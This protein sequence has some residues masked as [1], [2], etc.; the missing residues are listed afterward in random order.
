LQ[1][2]LAALVSDAIHIQDRRD[3]VGRRGYDPPLYQSQ[4]SSADGDNVW[5]QEQTAVM[6]D[7]ALRA[8]R[9]VALQREDS[10]YGRAQEAGTPRGG[11]IFSE[12]P[13]PAEG[14][15]IWRREQQMGSLDQGVAE[16]PWVASPPV[17]FPQEQHGG[18]SELARM[19]V[20]EAEYLAENEAM[21]LQLGVLEDAVQRGTVHVTQAE[22]ALMSA[23]NRA[24]GVQNQAVDKSHAD[25]FR[26]VSLDGNRASGHGREI[27][28]FVIS[29]VA[30]VGL[31]CFGAGANPADKSCK[32][33]VEEHIQQDNDEAQLWTEIQHQKD[34]GGKF[35]FFDHI[36]IDEDGG[37]DEVHQMFDRLTIM[38]LVGPA[39][40][41]LFLFYNSEY[42]IAADLKDINTPNPKMNDMWTLTGVLFGPLLSMANGSKVGVAGV[43]VVA[44]LEISALLVLWGLFLYNLFIGFT[45]RG[46]LRWKACCDICWWL[47]PYMGSF[48]AMGLL[49]FIS[50]YVLVDDLSQ[51]MTGMKD[52]ADDAGAEQPSGMQQKIKLAKA[53]AKFWSF[54]LV[55]LV[56]GF[57]AFLAKYR[58][59]SEFINSSEVSVDNMMA[60]LVFVNQLLGI[61]QVA[62]LI[63][64]R[65]F[66]FV[67]GGADGILEIKE[68]ARQVV[69]NAML[70]QYIF[71]FSQGLGG[72]AA[73]RFFVVMM[74]YTDM[75]FQ[76]MVLN[77]KTKDKEMQEPGAPAPQAPTTNLSQEDRPQSSP[78]TKRSQED[79]LRS[80]Q[81]PAAPRDDDLQQPLQGRREME[82]F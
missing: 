78:E 69:Y 44:G 75:D 68:Q 74:N 65:L 6:L 58:V 40:G 61:M 19:Q 8:E 39:L 77:E 71:Q 70:A 79:K 43:R 26:V 12:R 9:R 35:V 42:V 52:M 14:D 82:T 45:T 1:G 72:P 62:L 49:Y 18:T 63:R 3:T 54:R 50:P 30:I 33:E 46:R 51:L 15:K 29:V 73:S 22:N 80:S 37:F 57:D 7:A 31:F 11:T 64:R 20:E 28:I 81:R 23:G 27:G 41:V 4:L 60:S 56:I 47:I 48:S 67:F 55:C 2:N 59:A 53:M 76:T 25:T 17:A 32:E 10:M 5:R 16:R 36:Y 13:S 38:S 34:A 24:S 66:V 21:K